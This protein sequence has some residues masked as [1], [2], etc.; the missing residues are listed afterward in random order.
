MGSCF[1]IPILTYM[2]STKVVFQKSDD[3]HV[4][5]Y[6]MHTNNFH[7]TYTCQACKE[8]HKDAVQYVQRLHRHHEACVALQTEAFSQE[9][10]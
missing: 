5:E 7:S 8:E 4:H 3:G 6:R 2:S 9:Q 1:T 10:N